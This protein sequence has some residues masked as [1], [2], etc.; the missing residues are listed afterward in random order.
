MQEF[1]L[2]GNLEGPRRSRMGW[3]NRL[4]FGGIVGS[5]FWPV[6]IPLMVVISFGYIV[7]CGIVGAVRLWKRFS[8]WGAHHFI[9]PDRR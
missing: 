1:N 8:R 9:V 2:K 3:G 7:S 6:V 4:P 5:L